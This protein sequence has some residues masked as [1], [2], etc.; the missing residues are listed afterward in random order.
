MTTRSALI[1]VVVV[2][3][4]AATASAQSVSGEAVYQR[5]CAACHDKPADGRT[6][7]RETLQAMTAT[8][9][10]RT[11]D[12]GAMMTIAYQLRRDEREAVAAFLG[13]SGGEAPP[14]AAAF[15]R[16]RSVTLNVGSAPVWNGWSPTPDNARFATAGLAGLTAAQ[17]PRLAVKWAFGFDGDISAFSQ[18]T[19]IGNQLFIGS[20]GGVVHAL[21]ADTGCLQWTFQANGPIRSAMVA[22]PADGRH[23]L[24]F[25]DLTG[26]FYALN[27]SDG[28]VVWRTRPEEHEAVRFSAAPIVHEGIA[29]LTVASWEE[30]RSLNPEYPCCTFRGS[31]I[32]VRIRDGST[33]WKTYTI[34]TPSKPTGKTSVGTPT[35]GPSGAAVWG[36]PTLDV[37]RRRLYVTTGNNYS[38]PATTTSDAIM[39][40]DLDTGR[41]VWSK[42]VLPRDV[43]NSACSVTPVGATCPEGS[44]PDYD[45]GSPAILVRTTGGRELLLAGQK[46]GVVWAVDP[47]KNG[48]VMWETRVGLGGI[49]GGVQWGMASDGEYVYAAA[50]DAVATRTATARILNP[51]VGGGL[52]A[53]RIADGS[54]VWRAAPAPCGNRPNCSPAQSAALTAIPGVVFSGSLDGYLRA[55]STRDGAV[56]W[57]VDT[58]RSYDTVNGV[59]ASGGSIDGPGA[60]VSGGM[61]FVTS[62][63]MRFGGAP[64]NVLLAFAPP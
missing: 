36:A 8:R 22:V 9:I 42:Q 7:G 13:K 29:Y 37:K 24:L 15:C 46:S 30:S 31:V 40:L 5:R 27:A 35:F 33:V 23:L 17:V 19:V 26:W 21:R 63:Y 47:D 6:P 10:L 57:D 49:N 62:G 28:R 34:P 2:G 60:V 50:S 64:G 44:G 59:K 14:P 55:Y 18:P 53:L 56:I 16:D 38:L 48:E 25:G 3:A 11:L 41:I 32:G 51:T 39:A 58:V 61:V 1:A 52:T 54:M 4:L 20:A 45:F 43:Y 12:F